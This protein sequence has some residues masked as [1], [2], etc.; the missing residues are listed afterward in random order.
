[1]GIGD[2]SFGREQ[3]S[4]EQA[5]ERYRYMLRTAPPG[6]IEQAHEE[7]FARL[8]PAQRRT[9]LEQLQQ[10]TPEQ[11]RTAASAVRG[12][13]ADDPAALA[14]MATRAEVRQP[15]TIERIFGGGGGGMGL[16]GLMAGAFLSSLAGTVIGSMVAQQFFAHAAGEDPAVAESVADRGGA[17][18][19]GDEADDVDDMDGD[20]DDDL[21]GAG[22]IE[23]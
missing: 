4:D 23:V 15:G 16:G 18:R 10:A 7:A 21:G 6:V 1:M 11:E 3:Q 20:F 9:V 19:G 13:A 5:I 17:D 14:R 8:T 12:R 22:D 2:R